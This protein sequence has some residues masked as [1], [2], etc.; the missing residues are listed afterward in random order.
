M[1][2][3]VSARAWR[4][5]LAGGLALGGCVASAPD[6][7]AA[8]DPD[9]SADVYAGWRMFQETCAVCHGPDANGGPH[10]A[11][12]LPRR[13]L[14]MGPRRFAEAVLG[15]YAWSAP[16][17]PAGPDGADRAALIDEVLRRR[18]NGLGMPPWQGEPAVTAHIADLYAYLAARADGSLGTAPPPRSPAPAGDARRTAP[19]VTPAIARVRPASR[20]GPG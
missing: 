14:D 10:G 9:P 18:D 16:A 5:A 11:P 7:P 13:V 1:T 12:A 6:R 20:P 2:S 15:R 8:K 19:A 4:A 17:T 3:T